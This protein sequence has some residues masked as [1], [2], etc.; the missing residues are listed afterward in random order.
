MKNLLIVI[1][2]CPFFGIAQTGVNSIFS[3]YA[4]VSIINSDTS[5]NIG[6]FY[7]SIN[8]EGV[9]YMLSDLLPGDI[10]WTSGC[11]RFQVSSTSFNT[12]NFHPIDVD[13]SNPY[14]GERICIVRE[15]TVNG[16]TIGGLPQVA[17]GNGGYLSGVS[18]ST[19]ACVYNHYLK[20][21]A[22]AIASAS[23]GGAPGSGADDWGDD[24][25]RRS[26]D[27]SGTGTVASPLALTTTGVAAGTYNNV[28]VSTTGRVVAGSNASYITS[29]VDGSV[30]N[31]I[32]LPE[33]EFN[34]GRFLQTSGTSVFWVD[35]NTTQYNQLQKYRND[36]EASE[37]GL[38]DGQLYLLKADNPYGQPENTVRAFINSSY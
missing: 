18:N 24:Y 34:N 28:T 13:Y 19:Y 16:Y 35:V 8:N 1:L 32:E 2:F 14:I 31:E 17:D 36:F 30:T 4:D 15:L 20:N 27:F 6:A 26:S 25:V 37:A 12:I 10:I 3:G 23:G 21:I 11:S 33:Q 5:I 38:V 7:G 22:L 9:Y 29:E